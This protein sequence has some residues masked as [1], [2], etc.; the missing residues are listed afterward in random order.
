MVRSGRRDIRVR[1]GVGFQVAGG[2]R[3]GMLITRKPRPLAAMLLVGGLALLALQA[4]A[5]ALQGAWALVRL[6]PVLLIG[7]AFP[8]LL[9]RGETRVSLSE[10][11]LDLTAAT[12]ELDLG[13]VR[14]D[15]RSADI[16]DALHRTEVEFAGRPP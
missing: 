14:L 8:L 9:L 16:G 3:R 12:L 15:V 1:P 2:G 10:P 4:D 7:A 13:A 11:V 5:G 6:W